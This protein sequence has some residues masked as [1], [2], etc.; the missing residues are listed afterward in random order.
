MVR[1]EGDDRSGASV[2]AYRARVVIGLAVA[3]LCGALGIGIVL[4]LAPLGVW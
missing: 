1:A 2:T 3:A 4:A